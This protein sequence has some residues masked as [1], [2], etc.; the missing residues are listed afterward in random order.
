MAKNKQVVEGPEIK[1]IEPL[2]RFEIVKKVVV[3]FIEFEKDKKGKGIEFRY[4]VEDLSTGGKLYI[5]RPGVKWNFDFKVEIPVSYGLEEGR[6]DKIALIL[7][8]IKRANEQEFNKLWEIISH[9]Y[10]CSN[11]NVDDLLQQNP[12]SLTNPPPDV[13]LKVIKWLFIME[14][15][16]YW[17]Y[18]GRGFLY[19]FFV[20]VTNEVD[21]NR[22][23]NTL[24]G[25]RERKIKPDKIKSLLEHMGIGWKLP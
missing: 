17:H 2:G 23:E 22:L 8:K 5:H 12:I 7:R 25:I 21:N 4:P 11:N 6:H 13:L 18:E 10:H 19:N 14:D 24:S 20:F 9:L 15:I 1:I 3:A 16:I